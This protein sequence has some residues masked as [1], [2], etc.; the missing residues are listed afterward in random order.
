MVRFHPA[1]PF[2]SYRIWVL[3]QP[4]TL[5]KRVRVSLVPPSCIYLWGVHTRGSL[6]EAGRCI[7]VLRPAARA[8][9]LHPNDVGS[10]PT[11]RKLYCSLAQ[12]AEPLSVKQDA[13][14]RYTH[15]RPVDEQPFTESY[16]GRAP[17]S[18]VKLGCKPTRSKISGIGVWRNWLNSAGFD[19][20]ARKSLHV[21]VV[22]PRP[23]C[24]DFVYRH[25]LRL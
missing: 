20:A 6:S 10:S 11:V 3:P 25:Y 23:L 1:R 4:V 14:R 5:L 13:L 12:L 7:R 24:W 21:Q 2:W 15:V 8:F 9:G 22:S 16:V 19:P 17:R 18:V